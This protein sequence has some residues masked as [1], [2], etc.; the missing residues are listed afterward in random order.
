MTTKKTAPCTPATDVEAA[1]AA[2]TDAKEGSGA[3]VAEPPP[4]EEEVTE[5]DEDEDGESGENT[6][7]VPGERAGAAPVVAA[8]P[9]PTLLCGVSSGG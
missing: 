1:A 6:P 2:A 9:A 4:V 7:E 5:E 3:A 8:A